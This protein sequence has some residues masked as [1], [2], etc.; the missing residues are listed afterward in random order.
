M[1]EGR[2]EGRDSVYEI[3]REEERKIEKQDRERF[4]VNRERES[5]H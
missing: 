3:E 5:D 1:E 2:K 4:Y